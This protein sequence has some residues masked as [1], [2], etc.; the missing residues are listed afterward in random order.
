M[1]F[2]QV[3]GITSRL[4][5]NPVLLN[6]D[7]ISWIEEVKVGYAGGQDIQ[8]RVECN[9]SSIHV[10]QRDYQRILDALGIR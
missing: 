1:K 4:S 10:D 9:G 6:L 7:S 3:A 2:I 5:R 8:Y